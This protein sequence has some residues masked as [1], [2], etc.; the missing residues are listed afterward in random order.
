MLWEVHR[1]PAALH[2]RH[3]AR[4]LGV[5]TLLP[6][7]ARRPLPARVGESARSVGVLLAPVDSETSIPAA[8]AKQSTGGAELRRGSSKFSLSKVT[9]LKSSLGDKKRSRQQLLAELERLENELLR[10]KAQVELHLTERAQGSAAPAKKRKVMLRSNGEPEALTQPEIR[11][12][13]R[14]EKEERDE[15]NRSKQKNQKEAAPPKQGAPK[16][17]LVSVNAPRPSEA[18][19]RGTSLAVYLLAS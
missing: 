8:S 3:P 9:Q 11:A 1:L 15:K 6:L 10:E 2:P 4:H 19:F 13:A 17:K 16:I 5:R 7:L 18:R 12:R 14:R